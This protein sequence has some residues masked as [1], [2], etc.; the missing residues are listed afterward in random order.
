[1][2]TRKKCIALLMTAASSLFVACASNHSAP[3]VVAAHPPM[4]VD[5]FSKPSAAEIYAQ[6][7]LSSVTQVSTGDQHRF[8]ICEDD[9]PG[10]T[11]KTPMANLNAAVAQRAQEKLRA[12]SRADSESGSLLAVNRAPTEHHALVAGSQSL[13][14]A[15]SRSV[16]PVAT[17]VIVSS[18]GTSKASGKARTDDVAVSPSSNPTA[19]PQVPS[20]DQTHAD[21]LGERQ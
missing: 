10:A 20:V 8:V 11:P 3:P 16:T 13:A 4:V 15:V 14:L 17:Q 21:E 5:N 18:A 2:S 7:Y 1:M 19:L 6:R 9:C 12:R